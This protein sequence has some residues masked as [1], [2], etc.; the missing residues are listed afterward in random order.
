[1]FARIIHTLTTRPNPNA[2]TA[3][4]RNNIARMLI[5][6]GTVFFLCLLPF[7]II[8]LDNISILLRGRSFP[9]YAFG[10][11]FA[12]V[13]RVTTLL[14]SAV[15]PFLYNVSNAKYRASFLEAFTFRKSKKSYENDGRN[16]TLTT[17]S[18]TDTQKSSLV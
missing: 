12:W 5:L 17:G 11:I 6:N 13:G 2:E 15:N 1:M 18:L 14:N 16:F 7:R 9:L 3:T 8:Q 10:D 4:V